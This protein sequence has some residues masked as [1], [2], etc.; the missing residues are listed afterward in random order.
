MD[1]MDEA[2]KKAAK[3]I[4]KCL[5][6]AQ[7]GNDHEAE[8]A[9]RQAKALMEKYRLT[10]M[11]AATSVVTETEAVTSAIKVP[12]YVSWLGA[13]IADCFGCEMIQRRSDFDKARV[14]FIGVNP[15]PDLAGYTFDVLL[16]RLKSDLR[17]Y[18]AALP[19]CGKATQDRRGELF[20]RAW[21]SNVAK[22]VK[23]F[24]DQRDEKVVAA[25]MAKAYGDLPIGNAK[26]M[27]GYKPADLEAWTAGQSA[28]E[29]VSLQKPVME[30]KILKVRNWSNPC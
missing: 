26:L 20:C 4:A 27:E 21:L 2:T 23:I 14:V 22:Q 29:D 13:I 6:L 7:S 17:K 16:R 30:N 25:Y 15:K 28:S 12:F 24:A 5:A 1:G 9:L 18:R 3:K 19:R 10:E 11:D 8:A